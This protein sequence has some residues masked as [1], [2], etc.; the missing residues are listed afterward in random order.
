[1]K[2]LLLTLIIWIILM[3]IF[4]NGEIV[5]VKRKNILN[6]CCIS[7]NNYQE[8][9]YTLIQ[10]FGEKGIENS[11]FNVPTGITID[12]EDNLYITDTENKRIQK[13]DSSCNFVTKWN[14][15]GITKEI[16]IP[17]NLELKYFPTY[18]KGIFHHL[19]DITVDKRGFVYSTD[20]YSIQKYNLNGSYISHWCNEHLKSPVG[21]AIN[22]LEEMYVVNLFEHN[23]L[24]FNSQGQFLLEWGTE[25]CKEGEFFF[26]RGIAVDLDGNV[27]VTDTANH[28]I[29]KFNS[30]GNFIKKWGDYGKDCGQFN[31]PTGITIDLKE[32]IY[33]VDSGNQRIQK[34]NSNGD[35]LVM[36]P[37]KTRKE[38]RHLFSYITQGIAV[39][40]NEYVY[41]CDL[42]NN[43]IQKFAPNPEFKETNQ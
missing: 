29:Q 5:N 31:I 22:S 35:F 36:W 21:L 4:F 37:L 15:S 40:S 13:F 3:N 7:D 27:Y 14:F 2:K 17:E 32:N 11:Q 6:A 19:V 34:F 1:M 24:K 20:L 38:E 23:I 33:I 26:P 8:L 12:E 9:S 41:V 39:D 30:N 43:C 10:T 16:V 18:S 25:G 28:R 42:E